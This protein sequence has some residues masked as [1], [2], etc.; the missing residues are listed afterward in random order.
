MKKNLLKCL[1]LFLCLCLAFSIS[2]CSKDDD[3]PID[4]DHNTPASIIGEW[5]L[6]ESS[7]STAPQSMVFIEGGTGTNSVDGSMKWSLTGTSLTIKG[8]NTIPVTFTL[9]TFTNTE[10]SYE[11]LNFTAKYKRVK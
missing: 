8:H 2:S 11:F 5:E 7:Y 10:F 3:D 4:D 1:P 6:V 9:T